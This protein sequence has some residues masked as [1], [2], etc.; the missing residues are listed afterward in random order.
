VKNENFREAHGNVARKV[1]KGNLG[2][3]PRGSFEES[4]EVIVSPV[5]R[6][7]FIIVDEYWKQWGC[8]PTLRDIAHARGKSGVGNTKEIV[9]R[10]IRLGVLKR[11]AGHR[12]I[13]PTYINFR[14]ID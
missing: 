14:T 11:L 10:L 2:I 7:V 9:D 8:S 5:Q 3:L 12:S 13:R 1:V 4:M 6:E